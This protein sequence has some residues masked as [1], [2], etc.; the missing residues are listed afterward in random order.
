MHDGAAETTQ[1]FFFLIVDHK[2]GKLSA[3]K[4]I[5]HFFDHVF[6]LIPKISVGKS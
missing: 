1:Q 4:V 6:S 2:S 3:M 5:D